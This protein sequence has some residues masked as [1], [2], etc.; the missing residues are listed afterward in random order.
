[1]LTAP[2]Q[3][4]IFVLKHM[5]C[6]IKQ[7]DLS[8]NNNNH[9]SVWTEYLT[10]LVWE[11]FGKWSLQTWLFASINSILLYLNSKGDP[12]NQI[13]PVLGWCTQKF[14]KHDEMFCVLCVGDRDVEL[15]CKTVWS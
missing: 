13:Y 11:I 10:A 1:M 15:S 2:Y 5:V 8:K 7:I 4:D 12:Y 3:W 6:K 9:E 14:S